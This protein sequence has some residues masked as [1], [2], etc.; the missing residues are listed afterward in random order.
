MRFD[1]SKHEYYIATVNDGYTYT[2][3]GISVTFPALKTGYAYDVYRVFCNVVQSSSGTYTNILHN[4]TQYVSGT[5]FKF[6][7]IDSKTNAAFPTNTFK[8]YF[9]A[10]AIATKA[11]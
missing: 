8:I 6:Y 10:F 2:D 9:S 7:F 3:G 1:N 11:K 5:T 4:K